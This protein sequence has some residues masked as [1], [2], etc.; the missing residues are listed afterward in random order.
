[1][2]GR[3]RSLYRAQ[4]RREEIRGYLGTMMWVV[5]VLCIITVAITMAVQTAKASKV[6][7]A[8][9]VTTDAAITDTPILLDEKNVTD[10]AQAVTSGQLFITDKAQERARLEAERVIIIDPGH[11]GMD[12][13]CVFGDI[14][15]KDINRKI[16][17]RVMQ[18]LRMMGYRAELARKGDEYIDKADRV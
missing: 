17:Y 9:A 18:K 5:K 11:G 13:G 2:Y 7:A 1:M 16:A 14:V 15:E 8:E 6:I 4:R 3:S 12:G 10:I